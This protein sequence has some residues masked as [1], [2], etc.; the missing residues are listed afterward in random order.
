MKVLSAV[1]ARPQFIKAAPVSAALR[2]A[3]IEEILVHSGQHYDYGM[4]EVFF[5]ELDIP[6]P[7]VNLGVGSGSHGLQTGEMLSRFERVM[8]EHRPDWVI[9]HGDTNSTIAA[10]LAGVKLHLPVAHNEAGLRSHNRS[11]PEEHNR[12]LTDHC[13]DL[14]LCPTE[15]AVE[16]LARE[17]ITR[18]VHRVGDVMLDAA[19]R[20]GAVAEETSRILERLGLEPGG[21][22]LATLHRPYNVDSPPRLAAVFR[23]FA[24]SELPIVLPCHPRLRQRMAEQGLAAPA[25]VHAIDPVGYLDMLMLEKHARMILTDSGGVQK[26]AYFYGVP[27]LTL[28]PET[29]WVE[30]VAAGW[31]RLTDADEARIAEAMRD[32]GWPEDREPLFGDGSAAEEIVRLL[33][34]AGGQ[35]P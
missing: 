30:T 16:Q 3:G 1:G 13:A 12:V 7:H 8:L 10:A 28:R 25:P 11:M 33:A 4:S 35:S 32:E 31:N 18:G 26:E 17:G 22:R 21:Y 34:A 15:A 20:F 29:E 24:R 19:L 2:E 27:C 6:E 9:V 5:R 23:A 14:L